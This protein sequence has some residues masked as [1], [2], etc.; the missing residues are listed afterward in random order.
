MRHSVIVLIVVGL[1][2]LG[3]NSPQRQLLGKWKQT[4]A[5]RGTIEFLA[6]STMTMNGAFFAKWAVLD[7]GRLKVEFPSLGRFK[8]A[9]FSVAG[10]TLNIEPEKG[11]AT[12]WV[13]M[14][15]GEADRAEGTEAHAQA[16]TGSAGTALEAY[17][18][19]I[20]GRRPARHD[21][22]RFALELAGA[23][24]AIERQKRTM[25]YM[26]SIGT[27]VEAY[28]VDHDRYPA[29]NVPDAPASALEAY[30][31]PV[32]MRNVPSHDGWGQELRYV[33]G[34]G[35]HYTIYS[36]GADGKKDPEWPLGGITDSSA[37]IVFSDGQFTQYPLGMP[38]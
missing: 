14:K 16:D 30:L 31:T 23:N 38:M 15:P 22:M 7:D 12:G 24:T 33:S 8:T 35:A 20:E 10:D 4:D 6:D 11:A 36:F 29:L 21:M 32:Y 2:M 5:P 1:A 19:V 3:C 17:E 18:A 9:H 13:R 37:D 28:A 27:A 25:D 26:R 34:G